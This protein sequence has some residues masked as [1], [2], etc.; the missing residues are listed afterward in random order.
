ME[1]C[2]GVLPKNDDD[3]LAEGDYPIRY[4]PSRYTT[5]LAQAL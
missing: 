2:L 5:R 1:E 4:Q 3:R